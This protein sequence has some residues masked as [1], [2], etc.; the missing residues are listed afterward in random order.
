[1]LKH[2]CGGSFE[3]SKVIDKLRFRQVISD[4]ASMCELRRPT[5]RKKQARWFLLTRFT[6]VAGELE[7]DHRP[8]AVPKKRER[9]I[10]VGGEHWCGRCDQVKEIQERLLS[11]LGAPSRRLYRTYLN[12]RAQ[13]LW[14]LPEDVRGAARVRETKE[15][16]SRPRYCTVAH[17]PGADYS[18]RVHFNELKLVPNSGL[19]T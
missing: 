1:M 16:Q 17:E 5:A 6:Q 10:H 2:F 8:H 19:E 4:G 14:P 11:H 18:H 12:V 7:A 15:S 9:A 13:L 3:A